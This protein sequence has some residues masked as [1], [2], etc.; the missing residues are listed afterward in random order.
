MD[1]LT[2]HNEFVA[3][4]DRQVQAAINSE[5]YHCEPGGL[6]FFVQD[7]LWSLTSDEYTIFEMLYSNFSLH[8]WFMY[9]IFFFRTDGSDDEFYPSQEQGDK[10]RHSLE[11]MQGFW[12]TYSENISLRALTPHA[13]KNTDLMI[14]TLVFFGYT[15]EVAMDY[16]D[17]VLEA[18]ELYPRI[19]YMFPI[20]SLNAFAYS[21]APGT[22]P[23]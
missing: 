3:I 4:V 21:D 12:D 20:W 9:A 13:L 16:I 7:I 22:I 19:G 6:G 11:D 2:V 1:Q 5:D 17:T 14:R 15:P 10:F 18:F 23:N 8:L